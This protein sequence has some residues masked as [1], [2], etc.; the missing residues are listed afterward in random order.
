MHLQWRTSLVRFASMPAGAKPSRGADAAP[1]SNELHAFK[2]W[3][4]AVDSPLGAS[5]DTLRSLH[6]RVDTMFVTSD[7]VDRGA[8]LSQMP[9]AAVYASI[10]SFLDTCAQLDGTERP[11]F[12]ADMHFLLA[13]RDT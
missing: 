7:A 2:P 3:W 4:L 8:I 10:A 1:L 12:G 13:G 9:S 11:L 5:T 6:C